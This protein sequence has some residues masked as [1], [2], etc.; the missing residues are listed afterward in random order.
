[1]ADILKDPQLKKASFLAIY[2]TGLEPLIVGLYRA[3]VE[4]LRYRRQAGLEQM[5][6]QPIFFVD[7]SRRSAVGKLWG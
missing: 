5:V 6:V 7:D 2:Q 1:M 4:H 3:L